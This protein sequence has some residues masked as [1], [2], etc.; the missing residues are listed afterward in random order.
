MMVIEREIKETLFFFI[1]FENITDLL[2]MGHG[3]ITFSIV[4]SHS[5]CIDD[6]RLDNLLI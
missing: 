2:T 1:L 6:E 3:S 5:Y 4:L